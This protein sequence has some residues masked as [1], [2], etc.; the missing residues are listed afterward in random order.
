MREG[1]ITIRDVEAIKEEK[2]SRLQV[3][4]EKMRKQEQGRRTLA[5]LGPPADQT[6]VNA[7]FDAD[8]LKFF[9]VN[10]RTTLLLNSSNVTLL[11]EIS[12]KL[13]IR[14]GDLITFV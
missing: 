13:R 4:Y 12:H 3:A 14:M 6:Q 10:Y 8:P 11:Y 2:R 5:P 7:R 1:E 9:C